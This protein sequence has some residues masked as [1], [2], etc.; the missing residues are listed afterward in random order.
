MHLYLFEYKIKSTFENLKN[1]IF[2]IEVFKNIF[3]LYPNRPQ[4]KSL[5]L[6]Y[7]FII[8]IKISIKKS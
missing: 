5:I 2:N 7:Q 6:I 3:V 4:D 1:S 8:K